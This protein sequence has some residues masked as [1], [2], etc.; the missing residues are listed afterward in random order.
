MCN[1]NGNRRS[2]IGWTSLALFVG[3]MFVW[4]CARDVPTDK[5]G[6]EPSPKAHN[7]PDEGP[8]G[9]ALAEWGNEEFHAEFLVD[10]GKKEATV[11]ILDGL[12]DKTVP[13][14]EETLTLIIKNVQP[15]ANITLK[16]DPQKDDPKGRASRFTG[17]HDALAKEMEFEGEISGKIGDKAYTGEFKEKAHKGHKHTKKP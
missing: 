10:H 8:H 2:T 15:P 1:T 14:K 7:H 4:G 13:V 16:A 9:G 6:T 17:R 3:G 5:K 12:A 11:Y